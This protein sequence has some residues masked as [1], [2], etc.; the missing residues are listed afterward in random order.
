MGDTICDLQAKVV[1]NS[2]IR[3]TLCVPKPSQKVMEMPNPSSTHLLSGICTVGQIGPQNEKRLQK[4]FPGDSAC[5]C[6]PRTCGKM[7]TSMT[8]FV[9]YLL[10]DGSNGN[11]LFCHH[12]HGE[13]G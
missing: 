13:S 4:L 11:D 2:L 9:C 1:N 12:V 7:K 6:T 3:V 8:V 10:G 5:I